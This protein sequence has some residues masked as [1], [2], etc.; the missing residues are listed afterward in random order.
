[1]Q[2]GVPRVALVSGYSGM[3]KS[4]VVNE[5]HKVL[6][7]TRGLFASGKFDQYKRDIPYSTLA[8]AFRRL[9]RQLL[10]M[11][12]IELQGWRRA[13]LEA[14]GHN[15]ELL[16]NLVPELEHIIGKQPPVAVLIPQE[17]QA[18]FRIVFKR[19]LGVFARPEHPL[20]LFL[21]DVQ[22]QDTATLQ[23]MEYLVAEP[24]VGHVLFVCAY[25]DNEVGPAHPLTQTLE[26]MRD[27][28]A[29]LDHIVV[30][31]LSP[32][33]IAGLIADSLHCERDRAAPLAQL[34]HEKTGG[35]PFFA[36]QFATMLAHEG[37][38]AFDREAA[39]WDWDIERIKSKGFTEN[40]ADLMARKLDRLPDGTQKAIRPE[41]A[42]RRSA[43]RARGGRS[44]R[45]HL[46]LGQCLHIHA[47]SCAGSG[48][49]DDTP[50]RASAGASRHWPDTIVADHTGRDR[51]ED[52]RNR[53][54]VRSRRRLDPF[55][56]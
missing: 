28:G 25:R 9:V 1:M 6:A 50:G 41:R 36:I 20:V 51:S 30:T 8:P 29:K 38:L 53:K 31:L 44:C 49:R 48:I 33:D 56:R 17:A 27:S 10:E 2:D 18:R 42:G 39:A 32:A 55:A 45:S 21:D 52:L 40:V 15:G 54:S 12:D 35:N 26:A 46:P 47:R 23:L 19:F 14:L 24:D 22:W 16:L 13:L 11:N 4:S 37:L 34:V 5:L 3:G 43:C 7:S